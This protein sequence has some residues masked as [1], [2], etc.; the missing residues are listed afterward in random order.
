MWD[1]KEKI[2]RYEH[3]EWI[4]SLTLSELS[5][6]KELIGLVIDEKEYKNRFINRGK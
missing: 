2:A 5:E 1:Y 4:D 6:L 3:H